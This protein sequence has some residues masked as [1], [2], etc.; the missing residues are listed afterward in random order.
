[1]IKIIHK[2]E[3]VIY[4]DEEIKSVIPQEDETLET[5]Y[6]ENFCKIFEGTI[7]DFLKEKT[8]GES[9][10]PY[11]F[12]EEKLE[13]VKAQRVIIATKSMEKK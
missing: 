9:K 4:N 1:M 11:E 3:I 2:S 7:E 5:C 13:E 10:T 12:S 6:D 8:K